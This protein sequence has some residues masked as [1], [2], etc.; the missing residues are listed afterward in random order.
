MLNL[1]AKVVEVIG[2]HTYHF[3]PRRQFDVFLKQPP[4]GITATDILALEGIPARSESHGHTNPPC[5]VT[6][7]GAVR[8]G[9]ARWKITVH[10]SDP[11]PEVI[12]QPVTI[13]H[14]RGILRG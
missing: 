11:N 13:S 10:Y 7:R 12:E 6:K 5:F 8:I 14:N 4:P 9:P 1:V 2:F 3:P